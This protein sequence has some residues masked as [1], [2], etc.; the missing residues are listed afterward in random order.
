MI[1]LV[2]CDIPVYEPDS[3]DTAF[4]R[5]SACVR[6]YAGRSARLYDIP[7]CEPD[8]CDLCFCVGLG[9]CGHRLRVYAGRCAVLC[10]CAG[11][12]SC[13]HWL[14]VYAGRCARF[15]SVCLPEVNSDY[16]GVM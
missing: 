1:T 14:R 10:F 12:G 13:G 11:R 9:S 4:L 3:C 2:I 6:V 7:V 15:R 8:S 16:V 5:S